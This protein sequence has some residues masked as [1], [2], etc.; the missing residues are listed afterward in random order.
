MADTDHGQSERSDT[1]GDDKVITEA[2]AEDPPAADAAPDGR[3]RLRARTTVNYNE[4]GML[5]KLVQEAEDE[6]EEPQE[7]PSKKAKTS[8]RGRK[9]FQSEN[10]READTANA[11]GLSAV[12]LS[13]EEEQFLPES[14]DQAAYLMVGVWPVGGAAVHLSST[15]P[16]AGLPMHTRAAAMRSFTQCYA[17]TA[18][19]ASPLHDPFHSNHDPMHQRRCPW[20][21]SS[22]HLSPQPAA[23]ATTALRYS[24]P[25][26]TLTTCA[27]GAQPRAQPLAR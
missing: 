1:D 22:L 10:Q 25:S 21:H 19:C 7:R 16:D 20:L 26:S 18:Y 14:I 6:E 13:E 15:D 23:S 9:P 2:K 8:N 11:V 27:A 4:N 3:R 5:K 17:R 24:H 12:A